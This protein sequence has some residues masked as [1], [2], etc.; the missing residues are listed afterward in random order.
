MK[1]RLFSLTLLLTILFYGIAG[2]H[3]LTGWHPIVMMFIAI[4]LGLV[5]NILVYGILNVLGKSLKQISLHSITA[6]FSAVIVFTIL[7]CI[8]F[9]W[10]TLF[11]TCIIVFGILLCVALYQFQLKRNLLNGAFLL[12][13]LGGTG[14]VLFALANSGSDPYEKEVPLAFAH[15]NSFPPEPVPIQNPAVPGTFTVKTFTYGSGT[16]EQREEFSTGVKFKTNTVDGSLL[17]PDWKDKKKKWRERYWGFGAENFP[18]NGRV[19]MPEGEGPFP[20]TLIVHGNH[21][22]IDYSDNGYG[23]L[24]NLLA[25]RGIIAVSVDENFLNGHWSGDFRG[26]EMPARAWLLLKHLEQWRTWNNQEGHELSQK[27]DLD[28]IM[29]VGH[30]RGGEA[31]SIAAAY[32]PLPYFPDQALEKFNFNF[33]IKGVVALAPTDYRYDR[34]IILNNINFL[35]IQGS[36][37]A[38]EVSFWGMRP[39]RRLQYTDSISRFKAGVYIHHANHGQFNSTWGNSDF[40]AP[41][42]WLLNL[43][44]LLKEV[45]QQEAAKVFISSFAEATLKNSKEYHAI[46]KNVSVA[47]QWLPVEHY[48]TSFESSNF[49]TIADFEGDIDITTAKDSAKILAT[50]MALWKEQNLP[51]RDEGSQENNAVILGWDYENTDN[52]SDKARYEILLSEADSIPFNDTTSLQ[53]SLGAGNHEWLDF[54]LTDEQKEAKEDAEEREVPQLDFS[55][56]LTDKAGQTS[57]VK[58]SDIKGITKPLKTRFTKF[59]FLDKEMIGEDWEVQLQTFH[60]PLEAFSAANSTLKIDEITTISFIF[61]QTDYGV[62]VLDEIGVSGD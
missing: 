60:I 30:S 36:Y 25:S 43:N 9:G 8:G 26:K 17:I 45:Q 57:M 21:S 50:N 39:Y 44:P 1:N 54:N 12:I 16:D 4:I 18:L 58:V 48:L 59:G 13:L 51:T 14:Y 53:F 2:Y 52:S 27:V 6:V 7:K 42:K 20:I 32:N 62:V 23:Y 28:N 47:K 33:G 37:D 10:P 22:M 19:Y 55:I 29:L 11:Y 49:H 61:D 24:G 3:F 46:F 38:D 56:Q 5:I 31:V 41:S 15:E 35:S 34:K 40:G